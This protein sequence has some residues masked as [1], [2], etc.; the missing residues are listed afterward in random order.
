MTL[1]RGDIVIVD[2]PLAS[3]ASGKRRPAVVIQSDYYNRRLSNVIVAGVTTRIHYS[4]EATQLLIDP[5]TP[6]GKATKLRFVSV[7][8]CENLVTV[9]QAMCRRKIGA[10]PPTLLQQLDVCLKAS[11]GLS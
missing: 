5:A 6:E 1:H 11:L 7:V 9:E 10:L 4:H 2:F 3:G 8:S